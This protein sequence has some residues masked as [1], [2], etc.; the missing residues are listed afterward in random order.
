MTS[1]TGLA[2][3]VDGERFEVSI[4]EILST[5]R[6][7][8]PRLS[9]FGSRLRALRLEPNDA[10]LEAELRDEVAEAVAENDPRLSVLGA[11]TTREGIRTWLDVSF[12]VRGEPEAREARVP[13]E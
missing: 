12:Q 13:L 10:T 3:V 11:R 5:R 2:R 9:R 7:E 8:I 4:R 6:G 1:A